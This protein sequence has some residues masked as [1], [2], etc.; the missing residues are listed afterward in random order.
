MRF[1]KWVP[2]VVV[3]FLA[4]GSFAA[5]AEPV[6]LPASDYS[7]KGT[8]AGGIAIHYRHGNGKMRMEMKSPDMPQPMV[9]YFDVKTRKGVMV[10]N[11]PGMPP[12]AMETGM[13]DDGAAAVPRGNGR[14]IG[15]DRVAGEACDEWQIEGQTKEEQATAPV[16]CITSDGIM[17]RMVGNV[18]GKRQTIIQISEISRA[19]QDPKLLTPPAN[20]KP[21]QIP[22]MPPRR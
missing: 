19:P 5:R 6:P 22:G 16:A 11:M 20:L 15:S 1:A 3:A 17:L 7:I 12:M 8:M 13:D 21:M 2:V 10:M 9:G 14:R 4:S 18:D